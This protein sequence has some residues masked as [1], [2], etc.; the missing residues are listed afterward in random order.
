MVL[1]FVFGNGGLPSVLLGQNSGA[2]CVL[3]GDV[4]H[5]IENAKVYKRFELTQ[6]P[7]MLD[8][9]KENGVTHLCLAGFLKKPTISMKMFSFRLA[10]L[11]F[12]ILM[13]K[14]KGDNSLL[15]TI[16]N[17][18]EGKGFK[19]VS[20]SELVP[21]LLVNGGVLTNARPSAWQN[22][23]V[24]LGV[25]FLNDISKYDISQACVVSN[26][27]I[28]AVEGIEGTQQMIQRMAGYGNGAILV[29]MPK[30][31]QSLKVDM[32]TIGIETVLDCAKSGIAGIAI[33]AEATI[34]LDMDLTVKTANDN[35]IFIVSVV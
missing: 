3:L 33:K 21:S 22:Q 4:P 11:L 6:I 18:I 27:G 23:A 35:G 31:G 10:P 29:K 24:Q 8:F 30:N 9:F 25:S 20:A 14:N 32:P 7:H 2:V 13:L 17:Y 19:I 16:L 12:R 1:G 34:V 5:N 15:T 26:G 28:V